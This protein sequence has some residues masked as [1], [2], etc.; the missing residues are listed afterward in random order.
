LGTRIFVNSAV[1]VLKMRL[2]H[3]IQLAIENENNM[4][5]NPMKNPL[6]F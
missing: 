2:G 4:I 1:G 3:K 6:Y 5:I